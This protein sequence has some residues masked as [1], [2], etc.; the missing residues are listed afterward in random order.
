VVTATL[1]VSADIFSTVLALKTNG[2]ITLY[3]FF[4]Q[5]KTSIVND[6]QAYS[7]V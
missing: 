1:A 5:I 6:K 3:T 2:Y 7:T 4:R